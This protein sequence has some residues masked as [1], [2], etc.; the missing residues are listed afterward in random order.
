M[1]REEM[2]D[3]AVREAILELGA[4]MRDSAAFMVVDGCYVTLSGGLSWVRNRFAQIA[5][6]EG[7]RAREA[8]R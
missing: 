6:I 7:L 3:R 1:T 5:A 4:P 8:A 2:L